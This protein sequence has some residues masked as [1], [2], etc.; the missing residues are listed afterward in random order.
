MPFASNLPEHNSRLSDLFDCIEI[1][2][3]EHELLGRKIRIN[4]EINA[5]LYTPLSEL[6]KLNL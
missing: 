6:N 2:G 5:Q 1:I 4:T 3:R